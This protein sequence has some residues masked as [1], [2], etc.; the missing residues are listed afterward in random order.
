M[1]K[2][3]RKNCTCYL[4]LQTIIQP[5]RFFITSN[6]LIKDEWWK[7]KGDIFAVGLHKVISN[8]GTSWLRVLSSIIFFILVVFLG[9]EDF[10]SSVNTAIQLIDSLGMFKTDNDIYEKH[11]AVGF[12]IRIIT[13]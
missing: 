8:S 13:M 5:H 12:V 9:Y 6:K 7:N 1:K 11:Q 2:L 10:S 4:K 3:L